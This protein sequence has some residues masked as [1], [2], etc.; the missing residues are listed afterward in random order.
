MIV[1][2]VPLFAQTAYTAE[3]NSLIQSVLA[4]R[5]N[6]RSAADSDSAIRLVNG[7]IND[8]K[9]EA[10]YKNAQREVK[11]VVNNMLSCAKYNC[12]YEKNAKDPAIKTLILAQFNEA[13]AYSNENKKVELNAWFHVSFAEVINSSMQ[14]LSRTQAIKYGLKEKDDLD[15]VVKSKPNMS[16]ALISAGLWYYFAPGIGGGSKSKAKGYFL[17]AVQN[18]SNSYERYYANIYYSQCCFEDKNYADSQKYL[19]A[20]DAVLPGK[21]YV[22]TIK[23]CNDAGYSLY[24]YIS[25]SAKLEEKVK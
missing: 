9:N 20:A 13:D 19:S 2:F 1:G 7:Y 18:A 11:I 24:K 22:A 16:F 15:S 5:L 17:R 21:R 12:L 14:F 3:E 4:K 10:A 6:L 23:K 25:D 8:V